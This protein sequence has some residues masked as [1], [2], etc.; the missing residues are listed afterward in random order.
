M[1]FLVRIEVHWPP[2]GDPAR[3]AELIGLE[4]QRAAELSRE[5]SIVRLW[6][7]PGS[8]A[9][10]GIWQAPDAT[11]LHDKIRSL[12]FSPWLSV[13]VEPLAHHPSDPIGEDWRR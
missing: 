2:D 12:P 7:I 11:V 5:G 13:V 3:R 4:A 6:R 10:V 1:E 8:W 9:N